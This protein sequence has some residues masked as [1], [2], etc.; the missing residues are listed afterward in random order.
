MYFGLLSKK[1]TSY[2]WKVNL[3]NLSHVDEFVAYWKPWNWE[4]NPITNTDFFRLHGKNNNFILLREKNKGAQQ[5]LDLI[6]MWKDKT[7]LLIWLSL[8]DRLASG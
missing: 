3:W 5:K 8:G 2:D 1:F 4:T 7:S 6:T